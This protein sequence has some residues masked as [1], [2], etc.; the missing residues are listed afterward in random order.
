MLLRKQLNTRRKKAIELA[1]D[2]AKAEYE[3]RLA[4]YKAKKA[5]RH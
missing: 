5:W 1:D 4:A 2:D 3:K